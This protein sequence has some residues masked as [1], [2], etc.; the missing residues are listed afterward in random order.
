M[1]YEWSRTIF[2][3]HLVVHTHPFLWIIVP[4]EIFPRGI[5]LHIFAKTCFDDM[6]KDYKSAFKKKYFCS[7]CSVILRPMSP[8][9][10]HL[11]AQWTQPQ[12]LQLKLDPWKEKMPQYCCKNTDGSTWTQLLLNTCRR[13]CGS[14][15]KGTTYLLIVQV[16]AKAVTAPVISSCASWKCTSSPILSPTVAPQTQCSIQESQIVW[17]QQTGN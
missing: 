5:S 15:S 13:R 7:R 11:P 17:T 1:P 2:G 8:L 9:I 14:V 10:L 6:H 12:H 4:F 3:S 16:L